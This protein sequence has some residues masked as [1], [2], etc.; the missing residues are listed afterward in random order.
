MKKTL[1]AVATLIATSQ[2]AVA[3]ADTSYNIVVNGQT[4]AKG[5]GGNQVTCGH[6]P[7]H[8]VAGGGQ[9]NFANL[10]EGSLQVQQ[11]SITDGTG[12]S[13]LYDPKQAPYHVGGGD[14]QATQSGNTYKITGHIAPYQTAQG[15][16]Q[17]D[18]TPVPFEFDATCP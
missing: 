4:L 1:I 12:A 14:A 7:I 9:G 3:H 13:Y 8:I 11:I 17:K 16:T 6:N 15:Q 5:P 18:A 10:T 2:M